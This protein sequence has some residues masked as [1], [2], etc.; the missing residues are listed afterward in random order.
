MKI[1]LW[2]DPLYRETFY[3]V[4]GALFTFGLI[5]FPFRNKNPHAQAHWASIKSWLFAAPILL[6]LC[7]LAA[8]GPLIVL[9]L[10]AMMGAKIFFQMM[11]MYHR[12][13]FVW[14]TY[15]GLIGLACTIHWD[16]R[17]LYN[18][19]PMA[20]FGVICMIPLIRNSPKQEPTGTSRCI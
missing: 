15:F 8:P 12:S 1:A 11:G 18:I 13:N 6:A 7:G 14:A 3:L 2:S 5:L 19:G 20:F 10:V 16:L 17:E 9:T 4:V